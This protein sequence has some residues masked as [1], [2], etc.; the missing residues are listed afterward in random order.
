M[1]HSAKCSPDPRSSAPAATGFVRNVLI[2]IGNATPGEPELL[3]TA[4]R[5]LDD[6]SPL[7]RATAV[8]AFSRLAPAQCAAERAERLGREE[9]PLV[10]E[11]WERG[12]LADEVRR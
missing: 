2:A 12:A 1:R 8:W 11:E 6:H 5:S 10:R 4:R 7:V 3:A 9:D